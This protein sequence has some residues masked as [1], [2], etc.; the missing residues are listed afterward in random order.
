MRPEVARLPLLEAAGYPIVPKD[1][2]IPGNGIEPVDPNLAAA[3]GRPRLVAHLKRE[4]K[5]ALA[6][7]KRRA[8]LE[9]LGHLECER[10]NLIP[11]AC[12]GQHGNAVIEVHHAGTQVSDMG[13]GHETRLADLVCLCA[14]CHR[15]VHRDVEAYDCPTM[16]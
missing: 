9:Q 8:M 2:H 10:C 12:L 14:N 7:A 4:R 11:S 15:I 1:D 6:A 3:E 5:P 13:P 16:K